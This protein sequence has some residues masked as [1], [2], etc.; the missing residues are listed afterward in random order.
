MPKRRHLTLRL[1]AFIISLQMYNISVNV[2]TPVAGKDSASITTFKEIETMV[3]LISE[4]VFHKHN[5][6]PDS[7]NTSSNINFE[8][9]EQDQIS[10]GS[11]YLVPHP[12]YYPQGIIYKKG[13]YKENLSLKTFFPEVTTPP[14]EA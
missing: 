14:P 10:H 6:I 5:A 4:V 13:L 11:E 3:E 9:E 12:T 7:Q 1:V 2:N 8:E